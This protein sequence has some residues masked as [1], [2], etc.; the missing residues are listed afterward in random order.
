[1]RTIE[2]SPS[3][4]HA[5]IGPETV[6]LTL[7]ASGSIKAQLNAGVVSAESTSSQRASRSRSLIALLSQAG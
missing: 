2:D 3:V 4:R 1:M 6:I 5:E 7:A